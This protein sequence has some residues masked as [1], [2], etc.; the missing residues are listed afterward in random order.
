LRI[1]KSDGEIVL[2]GGSFGVYPDA[3]HKERI[4]QGSRS[5]EGNDRNDPA[6]DRSTWRHDVSPNFSSEK[7][8]YSRT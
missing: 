3:P 7:C 5:I 1:Q 6:S 2:Q 8:F 4:Y